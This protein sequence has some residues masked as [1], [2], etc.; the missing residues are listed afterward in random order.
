MRNNTSREANRHPY[1]RHGF[2]LKQENQ[3]WNTELYSE[4]YREKMRELIHTFD[5]VNSLMLDLLKK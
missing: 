4:S 5:H 3:F 2:W 1:M